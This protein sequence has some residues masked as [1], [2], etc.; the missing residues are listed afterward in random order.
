MSWWQRLKIDNF[1]LVLVAVVMLATLFPCTG[2]FKTFFGHL[3]TA[4]IALLFFMHGAKLS[5]DAILAGLG[6]WKLHL[7]VFASTFALFPLLGLGLGIVVPTLLAPAVHAGFLYLC[8]LPATVQSAIAF[9][10]LARGNIAAA[11]CSASA[12][13]LLGVFLSPLLVGL[14][15]HAQSGQ[16]DTLH[17]IGAIIL[18]LM[19][20]FILGHL[21]RPLI[22]PWVERHRKLIGVTDRSSI[23]LVIYTAFS[24]AVL[25]GIWQQM[26]GTS[27][28]AILLFS[29]LLLAIVLLTNTWAARALGF[30]KAD[31]ITIVFCGSKKSLANGI[32]MTNVL[33]PAATVGMMV[34]PLMVFHQ[35]QLMVCAVL[36]QRYAR[37]SGD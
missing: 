7:L 4:A 3:T 19:L 34:L 30:N 5:R 29:C 25:E 10:S 16:T 32:P 9:T 21:S 12:S 20:P 6:H 17:A 37:R 26:E 1:L 14:L 27:L 23:L 18:Q 36:A 11:I 15:M 13:S 22:G 2:V 24:A 31:E 28:L 8:A 35:I 33:F